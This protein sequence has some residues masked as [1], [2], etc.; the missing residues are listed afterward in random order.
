MSILETR[1]TAHGGKYNDIIYSPQLKK[2]DLFIM[3]FCLIGLQD[4]V[5]LFVTIFTDSNPGQ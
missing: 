5:E 3:N 2:N 4:I 1:A